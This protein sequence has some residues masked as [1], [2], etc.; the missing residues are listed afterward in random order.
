[1]TEENK[2][3]PEVL[4]WSPEAKFEIT[5]IQFDVMQKTV[6]LLEQFLPALVQVR[7]ELWNQMIEKGLVLKEDDSVYTLPA[8]EE[9]ISEMDLTIDTSVVNPS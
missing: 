4:H 6:G 2:Q 7:G 3:T 9:P 5:G 8:K 1:M